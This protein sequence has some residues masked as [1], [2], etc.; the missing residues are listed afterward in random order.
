MSLRPLTTIPM[1]CRAS[2]GMGSAGLGC[3][4]CTTIT[5]SPPT[6]AAIHARGS[7]YSSELSSAASGARQ[8]A[9]ASPS[10][11][12]VAVMMGCSSSQGAV[13]AAAARSLNRA[14]AAARFLGRDME[15]LLLLPLMLL[16]LWPQR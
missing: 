13:S 7:T 16:P 5:V 10:S 4:A 9:T 12:F 1:A 3:L 11:S 15:G 8:L 2:T 6:A 14:A